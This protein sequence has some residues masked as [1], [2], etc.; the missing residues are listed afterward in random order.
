M[1]GLELSE[2]YYKEYG[3]K[4]LQ[5]AF[6][7]YESRIA[8]GLAGE[9]SECFGFD[10]EVSKDH[11]FGPSFC[12]W[13]S[14][15]DYECI[16]KE[17]QALYESLPAEY[18]GV[19]FEN[20][21]AYSD[22]RRGV[23]RMGDF[24]EK[25]TGSRDG[26]YS[27]QDFLFVPEYAFAA[28]VNG[29]VFEDKSGQFTQMRE[30]IKNAMPED[31]RLKKIAAR[32]AAMAQS[33]Q[34][35]FSRCIRHG[36]Y[37]AAAVALS[38]F[39]KQTCMMVYLLNRQ[40]CP[41]YKWMFRGVSQLEILSDTGKKLDELLTKSWSETGKAQKADLIEDI[42]SEIIDELKA[43]KLTQVSADYLETHAFSIM[44][45]IENP[46]IRALHVLQG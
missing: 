15:S 31:I 13:L 27:W 41:Y 20:H 42:C 7:E 9:G 18:M 17:M 25:L 8:T 38:E 10:D 11:D 44:Q 30:K 5:A 16:G 29:K 22:G 12:I 14:D 37:G 34:Y 21:S 32:A 40:Y 24:F 43:Q 4:M 45:K 23:M 2:K 36:E 3:K 33:G 26:T 46:Q 1:K 28:A 35:N 19:R 39:A 6:P